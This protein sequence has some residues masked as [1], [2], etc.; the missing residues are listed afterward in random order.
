[1]VGRLGQGRQDHRLGVDQSGKRFSGNPAV[2]TG[3]QTR[4]VSIG[5][6]PRAICPRSNEL[7]RLFGFTNR[8]RNIVVKKDGQDFF[9][10]N[11]NKE[12]LFA[13]TIL[14]G[15]QMVVAERLPPDARRFG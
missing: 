2:G 4:F 11:H 13:A 1:M 15:D 12:A 14:K 3:V 8:P 5:A 9:T 6:G 10:F 7:R